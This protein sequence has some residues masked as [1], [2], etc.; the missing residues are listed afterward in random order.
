MIL[1]LN[2]RLTTFKADEKFVRYFVNSGTYGQGDQL[3]IAL[4]RREPLRKIIRLLAERPG[5]SNLEMSRALE[6]HE[7]STMR[8]VK[9]LVDKGVV[10]R[11]LLPDGKIAYSLSS[12]YMVNIALK[13]GNHG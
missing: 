5:L 4:M 10:T 9:E 12:E 2:H 8:N 6:A 7:S 13:F 11:S 1:D 3:V